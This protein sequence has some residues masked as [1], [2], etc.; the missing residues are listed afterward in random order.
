MTYED[1]VMKNVENVEK[2]D[3]F[4]CCH[5]FGEGVVAQQCHDMPARDRGK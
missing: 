5:S 4:L 1:T 3:V 2:F